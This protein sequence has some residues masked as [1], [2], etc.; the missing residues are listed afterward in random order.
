MT[1]LT[2]DDGRALRVG[3]GVV[4]AACAALLAAFGGGLAVWAFNADRFPG[5][6]SVSERWT[7]GQVRAVLAG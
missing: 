1:K 2:V 5:L 4:M 6:H 3:H 7:A